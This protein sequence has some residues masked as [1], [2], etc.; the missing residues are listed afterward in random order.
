VWLAQSFIHTEVCHLKLPCR[1][2][3]HIHLVTVTFRT[4]VVRCGLP[5]TLSCHLERHQAPWQSARWLCLQ[6]S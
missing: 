3:T 6:Y 5:R 2:A 4:Y 1:V